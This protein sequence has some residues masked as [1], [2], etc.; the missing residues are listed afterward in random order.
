MNEKSE[1]DLGD[2]AE[3]RPFECSECRKPI[4]VRYTEVIGNSITHTVMCADCPQLQRRL[5]GIPAHTQKGDAL[6]VSAALYCGNCGTS[7]ETVRMS[8]TLGCSTCYEVFEDIILS[9]LINANRVP[10]R[11]VTAKKTAPIHIGRTP[12][13]IKEIN[14]SVR[15]LALNE[16]LAETLKREDYEQAARLR[17][18]IK[19]LTERGDDGK[20]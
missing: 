9:E 16:A 17:D 1:E 12:G 8:Y 19:E 3:D 15:L 18:Q 4:Y 14:P 10:A 7:L 20:K 13:E 6:E 2:F 5:H 11:V